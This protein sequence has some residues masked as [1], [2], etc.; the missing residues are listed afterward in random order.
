MQPVTRKHILSATP[1][2]SVWAQ[3]SLSLVPVAHL[4][5]LPRVRFQTALFTRP[6]DQKLD[7]GVEVCLFLGRYAI[8]TYFAALY[9]LEVE[10]VNQ[11]IY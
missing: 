4:G 1:C 3:P 9:R 10:C 8:A 5:A 2:V 7:D 6:L 11:L